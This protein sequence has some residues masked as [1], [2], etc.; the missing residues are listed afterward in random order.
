MLLKAGETQSLRTMCHINHVTALLWYTKEP[1][2]APGLWRST[3]SL[4]FPE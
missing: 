3:Y 4:S 1:I 2:W